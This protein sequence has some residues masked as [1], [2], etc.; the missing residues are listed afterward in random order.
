MKILL[1]KWWESMLS[2]NKEI[3]SIII[4]VYNIRKYIDSC[5]SSI[6]NQ[7]YTNIEILLIDDG[8]TDGSSQLCDEWSMRDTRIHCY[9]QQNLG[10]SVARNIG[11]KH[12]TGQYIMF[13]DGDDEI[14]PNMCEKLLKALIDTDADVS[15][16]GFYN[17]FSDKQK[18]NIPPY[19]VM[20]N[21][22][23]L[24]ALLTDVGFF[25]AVWN[26]MFRRSAIFRGEDFIG[27]S[28]DVAVSEDAL[29]LTEI[30]NSVRKV[31]SVPDAL[32]YWKRRGD[33][34]T[35]GGR[36]VQLTPRY[37]TTLDAHKK[38]L[39]LTDDPELKRLMT[40][41]Y[42]GLC[43]DIAVEALSCGNTRIKE[44]TLMRIRYDKKSYG[45]LD[46]FYIKLSLNEIL[47]NI[48][49]PVVLLD[50]INN[51]KGAV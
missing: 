38:M 6:I 3:I 10:V 44:S 4:P 34:A 5:L 30:L 45:R 43:R 48:N 15:Y 23:S 40:K 39:E 18:K 29:W 22:E 11:L 46:L 32:Y 42:L 16:C 9:H 28:A 27:F 13:V 25:S 36:S 1:K 31:V 50:L 12:C 17:I 14:A 7:T 49:C 2:L 8:S 21:L 51:I 41:R 47:L 37:L 33:S 20:N 19:K 35:F 26:K 24:N